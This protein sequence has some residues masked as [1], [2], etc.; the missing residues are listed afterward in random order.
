MENVKKNDGAFTCAYCGKAY[1]TIEEM[2][3]C[4]LDCSEKAKISNKENAR[5]IAEEKIKKANIEKSN[6]FYD[7][8]DSINKHLIE[9]SDDITKYLND[10][11]FKYTLDSDTLSKKLVYLK[12]NLE[13]VLNLIGKV[14]NDEKFNIDF[15]NMIKLN[16]SKP[17]TFDDVI[18][19]FFKD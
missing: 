17:L 6:N 9:V 4:I 12:R 5:R 8:V 1:D 16:K 15:N 19:N 10:G 18:N 11:T 2:A 13:T 14:R 7:I 3:R